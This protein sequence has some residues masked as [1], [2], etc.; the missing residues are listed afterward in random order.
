MRAK[1]QQVTSLKCIYIKEEK[2]NHDLRDS[3]SCKFGQTVNKQKDG[4]IAI[5]RAKD[6]AAGTKG[7]SI[8]WDD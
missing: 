4:G 6:G 7:A 3:G 2:R 5:S 8:T 1:M